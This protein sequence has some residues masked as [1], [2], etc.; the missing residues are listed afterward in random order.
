MVN[1]KNEVKGLVEENKNLNKQ[2]RI[3]SFDTSAFYNDIERKVSDELDSLK[4]EMYLVKELLKLSGEERANKIEEFANKNDEELMNNV[5]ETVANIESHNLQVKILRENRELLKLTNKSLRTTNTELRKSKKGLSKEEKVEI[6]NE[7]ELNKKTIELNKIKLES[8]KVELK[9][10]S[11]KKVLSERIE[12]K[13]DELMQLFEEN[14]DVRTLRE[15]AL[16]LNNEISLFDSMLSRTIEVDYENVNES[17]VVIQ[18]YYYKVLEKLITKGFVNSNGEHYVYFSSSAGQIRQK[19][20]IWINKS[21]W[22]KNE[23]TLMCGLTRDKINEKGGIN[24]TKYQAYKALCNSAS[25]E[26]KN[27]DI[28]K[29]IVVDD[30]EV[31]VTTDVDYIDRDKYEIKREE[32]MPIPIETTDGCGIMLN[33]VSDKSFQVRMAHVKGLLVSFPF[34][35]FLNEVKGANPVVTDIYGNQHNVIKEGIEIIFTK[36]QFKM[37]SYY[38]DWKEYQDKF[39]KYGCTAAKLNEED[40]SGDAVLCY[41]MLQSLVDISD[42]E[43]EEIAQPSKHMIE[44]IGK[45]KD[46]MLEIMGAT[47]ENEHKNHFQQALLMYPNL[48]NDEH[49]KE[50]IK[51]KKKSLVE[52]C[53]AGKLKVEGAKYTFIIP[54]LYAFAQKIF[55]LEVTGLLDDGEVYC[56]LYDEGDMCLLR[57]PHLYREWG[58]RNNTKTDELKKWFTTKGVY[59]SIE[60]GLSKLLQYDND[61]DK[62]LVFQNNYITSIAKRNMRGIVPLYY[63]MAKADSEQIN[64]ES[65]YNSL[66]EAYKANIGIV[67]ND[68]TKIWSGAKI[69]EDAIKVIK[70]LCMESNF[71]IDR[72]KTNFMTTRPEHVDEIIKKYTKGKMPHF[73]KYAK[74]SKYGDDK[75]GYTIKDKNG[76]ILK[77]RNGKLIKLNDKVEVINDSTVNRLD[78]IISESDT[79]IIFKSVAGKLDYKMLMTNPKVKIDDEL[80]KQIIDKYTELDRKKK[81]LMNQNEEQDGAKTLPVYIYIRKELLKIKNNAFYITD[82]LVKHL[83][84]VKKSKS[85]ETLFKSFGKEVVENLQFN[86]HGECNCK[87]CGT[88]F[89]PKSRKEKYCSDECK[90]E[91]SK[92]QNKVADKKYKKN[93]KARNKILLIS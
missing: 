46:V 43:L 68:I 57:S 89:K 13:K 28:R 11:P 16:K 47:E 24:L 59:T 64:D 87:C 20:G 74:P 26:W 3:Y 60:D 17:I 81:W 34:D 67:S 55:G 76:K 51:S 35:K 36:S 33:S 42:D 38:T 8:I 41:Q 83:C 91:M 54:D 63:E 75:H 18:S 31:I 37:H 82:V 62:S 40:I 92:K 71:Q 30:L 48:L 73:F 12:A 61:G 72:A 9:N 2:F 14:N 7:I 84:L 5:N 1:V 32:K 58:I 50:T 93:K 45:S 65:L 4:L 88:V 10:K 15:D 70:Y 86:L 85:K 69:D 77:D 79:R 27:F 22:E 21:I 78:S 44:Q 52:S 23:N 6:D 80:A 29:T 53:K 25:I 56:E 39:V 19:K 49:T 90:G 66:R